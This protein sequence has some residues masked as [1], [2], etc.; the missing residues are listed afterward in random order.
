MKFFEDKKEKLRNFFW[1]LK[2]ERSM[3]SNVRFRQSTNLERAKTVGIYAVYS[4][5][6]QFNT[7]VSFAKN[8]R[9]LGKTVKMLVYFPTLQDTVESIDK[10][11]PSQ[12]NFKKFPKNTAVEVQRFLHEDFDIFFDTSLQFHYIDVS[13][14]SSSNAKFK[15]GKEGIWNSQVNDF[16]LSF[17][18]GASQEEALQTMVNYLSVFS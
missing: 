13:V 7:V 14:T 11:L 15:V 12:I 5:D 17:R 8:M 4:N 18:D 6:E 3:S 10:L 2:V 16:S 9:Q 1:K